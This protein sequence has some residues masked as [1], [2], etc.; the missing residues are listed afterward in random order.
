[1]GHR[2]RGTTS[3]LAGVVAV[4][5]IVACDDGPDRAAPREAPPVVREAEVPAAPDSDRALELPACE[6]AHIPE[7]GWLPAGWRRDSTRIGPV[8]VLYTDTLARN[9][10]TGRAVRTIFLLIPP[11][12]ELTIEI[13][14]DFARRVAFVEPTPPVWSGYAA[15][16]HPLLRV[17]NCPPI[18]PE[19]DTS[20][21]G[22]RYALPVSTV[23]RRTSCVPLTVTRDGNRAHRRVISF[24]AGDCRAAG[25]PAQP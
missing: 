24:G 9:I 25:A 14:S 11:L 4:G 22:D 13:A 10:R 3:L 23:V 5:F 2:A 20:A 17:K 1:L 7:R 12:R 18:P 6:S 16:L 19:L 21:A 8:T 15:D